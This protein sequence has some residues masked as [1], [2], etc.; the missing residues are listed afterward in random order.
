VSQQ[1]LGC[2]VSH[3][4]TVQRFIYFAGYCICCKKLTSVGVICRATLH[5]N[6]LPIDTT[7]QRTALVKELTEKLAAGWPA[8]RP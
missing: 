6:Q 5:T 4:A 1:S 8:A 3:V 2:L 7:P